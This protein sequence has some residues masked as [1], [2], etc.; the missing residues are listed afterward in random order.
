MT[1]QQSLDSPTAV[2]QQEPVRQGPFGFWRGITREEALD[3][4]GEG[5][6]IT[7]SD[8]HLVLSSAPHP[9]AHFNRYALFFTPNMGTLK[10]AAL[11]KSIQTNTFGE[12]L[13]LAFQTIREAIARTYGASRV[14]DFLY[15]GSPYAEPRDW[16]AGLIKQERVLRAYWEAR[17]KLPNRIAFISLDVRADALDTGHLSLKYEFE[18]WANHIGNR[19]AKAAT[20]F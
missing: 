12:S 19:N 8:R 20:A 17:P 13:Q 14:Q 1:Q 11:G 18:G 4:T 10:V 2:Q 15:A 7:Q 6:L 16:M 5:A 9:H 3:V